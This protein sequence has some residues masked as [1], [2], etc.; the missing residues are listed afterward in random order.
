MQFGRK[1]LSSILVKP[2]GPD[3]NLHCT[4]C[5]YLEKASLFPEVKMHR[6]S[7]EIL[8]EM[9]RQ[10][11]EQSGPQMNFGWQGGEP[12]LMGLPFFEKAVELQKR[13]G[14]G[15]T[16]GNGLQTN[17]VLI[18]GR[19]AEFL[20]DNHF[21]VGLSLDGPEHIH[22]R[23]RLDAGGKGSWRRVVDAAK[24]MLDAG[25]EVNALVVV[26]DYSVNF[27]EE[28]YA[29]HKELGLQYMQFIP[30]VERLPDREGEYAPF[31]V[32]SEKY[33][34][35]L[36]R[37]FD[38]WMDDFEGGVPTTSV[39]WFDSVFFTYVNFS[40]PEC[41]LLPECGVYVVVEHN[42]DVYSCDFFVDPRW[43][44]GNIM[45]DRLTDLLNSPR[46]K[47][48]GL[49]KYNLPRE[50]RDCPWLRHCWGGCTK[51]RFRDGNGEQH[52]YLCPGY[53]IFFEH[54]DGRLRALAQTWL[55]QQ[56]QE[57][58]QQQRSRPPAELSA[59]GKIGRNDPCPCGSGL[60]YKHCHGRRK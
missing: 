35:F 49:L 5:F 32:P 1:L 38:L 10:A 9:I 54:A 59:G 45:E 6:M 50:C 44:L 27:P 18:D 7:T 16:I 48:F 14:D 21:L 28:I 3:C 29:F 26:N 33:G 47:E 23:Y 43:K 56:E 20:R 60:K 24:R 39:R 25:V 8:E 19:W 34:R 13:Y 37:L 57:A 2:A 30:C 53:K 46:Q 15:K 40:P 55:A 42:G 31:T 11:L 51:D 22:D 17:G 41:T 36:A 52:A 12:T 58:H 4:Y